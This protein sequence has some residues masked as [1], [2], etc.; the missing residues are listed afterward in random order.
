MKIKLLLILLCFTNLITAQITEQDF[1]IMEGQWKG[2]LTY[3]DY[4]DDRSQ[5][6]LNCTMN[7]YW[8]KSLGKIS[9]GFKEPNGS[10][11]HD[12]S[13]VKPN[14]NWTKIKYDGQWYD[15][16]K[17]EKSEN[18]NHWKLILTGLGK[19]NRRKAIIKQTFIYTGTNLSI[20]KEINYLGTANYLIRNTYNFEKLKKESL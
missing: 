10:E 9:I 13:K 7:L 3:T 12:V 19:D 16:N 11:F 18:S 4:S 8:K 1:Q 2:T 6:T 17:F 14:N 20:T 15:I 5:S